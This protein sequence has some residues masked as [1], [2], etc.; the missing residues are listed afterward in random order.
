[1]LFSIISFLCALDAFS[2][3]EKD[4]KLEPIVLTA[5]RT[6][7]EYSK[8]SRNVHIINKE[9]IERSGAKSIE[10]LLKGE[11]AI[12]MRNRGLY[13]V[14]SDL[15]IRGST[16]SQNL[17]LVNGI[18]I[19]DPQTAHHN[20]DTGLSLDSIERIEILPG[21]GSSLYG[22]DAFGGVVNIIT[23]KPE[24]VRILLNNSY[25]S[26]ETVCSNLSF[27]DCW[28][29]LSGFFSFENKE[30]NGYRYDTDFKLRTLTSF[31]TAEF[32]KSR[33]FDLLAGYDNKEFGANDFYAPYPSKEWTETMFTTMGYKTGDEIMLEPKLYFRRHFDKFILDITRPGFYRNDH[34]TDSYGTDVQIT[35]PVYKGY[36]L[37]GTEAGQEKIES[38]NLGDHDRGHGAL[39]INSSIDIFEKVIFNAGLR[40]DKYEKFEAQY[41]PSAGIAYIPFKDTKFRTSAGHSFRVPSY[42][43]LYY[44]SPTDTGNADLSPEKADSFEAGVDY[45]YN[46]DLPF[47]FSLTLFKRKEKDL[48]DWVKS[49]S[50]AAAYEAQNIARA[51][52]EGVEAGVNIR[53]V[54]LVSAAFSYSY[55]DSDIKRENIYISKYALNNPTNQINACLDL[56]LPFG[57]QKVNFLYKDRKTQSDYFLV[58]LHFSAFLKK[59]AELYLDILNIFDKNYEDIQDIPMPGV[60]YQAGLKIEF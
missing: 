19:N 4:I 18:R 13:G 57:T 31:V 40:A 2:D 29:N 25:G 50:S 32:D 41:S 22:A 17:I 49:S 10:E 48:I 12:D 42:T 11:G 34:M 5:T 45:G 36:I 3:G 44:N 37:F 51:D 28:K 59:N 20:F 30:S 47:D 23:K 60:S 58:D 9:S 43:E 14:Q 54:D 24:G 27:S 8:I 7:I 46:K 39:F 52:V 35:I 1:M 33:E 16:Y 6:P 21:H 38:T 15:S 53:P 26:N 55:V 56:N